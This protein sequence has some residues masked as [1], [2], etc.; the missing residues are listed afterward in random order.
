[1]AAGGHHGEQNGVFGTKIENMNAKDDDRGRTNNNVEPYQV[2][3]H[4]GRAGRHGG[5]TSA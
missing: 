5:A 4:K 2:F 3:L 1:M